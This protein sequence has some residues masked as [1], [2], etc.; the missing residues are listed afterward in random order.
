MQF[1]DFTTTSNLGED[2]TIEQVCVGPSSQM[3]SKTIGEMQI[4]RQLGV[5][6]MAIRKADGRMIFNP[7]ADTAIAGGD[8]L[9]VMGRQQNLRSLEMLLADRA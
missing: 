3:A 2:I 6:V 8:Y 7:Q 4:G 5:I 9:I 1:L